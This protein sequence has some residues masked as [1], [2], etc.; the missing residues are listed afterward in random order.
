MDQ[1][2]LKK[3]E[4]Y[5]ISLRK[6]KHSEMISTKRRTNIQRAFERTIM[7]QSVEGSSDSQGV[8]VSHME[9]KD[10]HTLAQVIE[11]LDS[12]QTPSADRLL[13]LRGI[14]FLTVAAGNDYKIQ[15]MLLFSDDLIVKL[16]TL[17]QGENSHQLSFQE[18]SEC[19]WVLTNLACEAQVCFKMLT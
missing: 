6:K 5:A 19:L 3:R 16:F 17:L 9:I 7:A 11:Y 4:D 15:E 2:V 8:D 10:E 13:M 1:T 12:P 14:R 18:K